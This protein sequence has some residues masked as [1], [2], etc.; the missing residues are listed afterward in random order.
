LVLARDD[1]LMAATCI[2]PQ[3][4]IQKPEDALHFLNIDI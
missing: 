1:E 3:V 2:S 4:V